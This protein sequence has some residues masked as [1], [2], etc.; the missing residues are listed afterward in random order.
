MGERKKKEMT[1]GQCRSR[2][3][4]RGTDDVEIKKKRNLWNELQKERDDSNRWKD[5]DGRLRLDVIFY[6]RIFF[7]GFA[8]YLDPISV[9]ISL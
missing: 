6:G 5:F 1:E 4:L 2:R 9:Q 8:I 3:C 7:S